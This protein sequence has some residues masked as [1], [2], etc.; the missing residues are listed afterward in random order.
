MDVLTYLLKSAGLLSLF[1]LAYEFLLKKETFFDANRY[2][3]FSGI[4]LAALLPALIFEKVLWVAPAGQNIDFASVPVSQSTASEGFWSSLTLWE[5]LVFTWAAIVVILV[6][7]FLVQLLSLHFLMR[8]TKVDHTENGIDYYY[9]AQEI[10]PFSF[11]KAVVINPGIYAQQELKL[12]L[13]HEENHARDFHSI[14]LL[15]GNLTTIFLWFNPLSWLYLKRIRE[16]LEFIADQKATEDLASLTAY[17]E[18]LVKISLK[19]EFA[20]PVTNFHNSFIKKRIVMLHKNRSNHKRF[21]KAFTMLPLLA[22]FLWSFNVET[23]EKY[24]EVQGKQEKRPNQL[25]AKKA[26]PKL[27]K[28]VYTYGKNSTKA[29][30]KK[31][32]KFLKEEL[33]IT[34]SYD[35]L[36]FT[37]N[38]K[39]KE[40]HIKVDCNDG[41]KGSASFNGFTKVT[42]GREIYFYRNYGESGSPFGIGVRKISKEKSKKNDPLQWRSKDSINPS[43][44]QEK[45]NS[46]KMIK[47]IEQSGHFFF[48]QK[49]IKTTHLKGQYFKIDGFRLARSPKAVYFNGK[50]PRDFKSEKDLAIGLYLIFNKEGT[51]YIMQ[52]SAYSSREAQPGK[53]KKSGTKRIYNP[54]YGVKDDQ[55]EPLYYIDGK[56]VT[57][58]TA[59]TLNRDNI[60]SID[61]LKEKN[62]IQVY[63]EKAKDGVILITTKAAS[64]KGSTNPEQAKPKVKKT[65]V[66][67]KQ[68]ARSNTHNESFR[69][70]KPLIYVNGKEINE[71]EMDSIDRNTIESANVLKRKK[72]LKNMERKQKVVLLKLL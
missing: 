59:A 43:D 40:L 46:K 34:L 1:F 5:W 38:G 13:K 36:S 56:E 31:D 65:N 42:P 28:I 53:K 29:E 35:R 26:S 66:S 72:A 68:S 4:L 19:N 39:L 3:L 51:P 25:A 58:G 61:I 52:K 20:L 37:E 44:S 18:S 50:T 12:I 48:N 11:F 62:A 2:F 16:N 14:D 21:L 70:E 27:Q 30:L 63:G 49:K 24:R 41:Y 54:V 47:L 8:K 17:Q 9:T 67:K 15:V 7:R 60:E 23:V 33:G 6:L 71:K 64:K 69:Q 57:K 22:I 10:A 45:F 55:K 32:Q